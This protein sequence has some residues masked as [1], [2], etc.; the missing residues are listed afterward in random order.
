MYEKE[1]DSTINSG[2]YHDKLELNNAY[3]HEDGLKV[4]HTFNGL[5]SLVK[6]SVTYMSFTFASCQPTSKILSQ[7]A[8]FKA[9]INSSVVYQLYRLD[10]YGYGA[11]SWRNATLLAY[12]G[13]SKTF[14]KCYSVFYRFGIRWTTA[15]DECWIRQQRLVSIHYSLEQQLLKYMLRNFRYVDM[16]V[17]D[18]DTA[19]SKTSPPDPFFHAHI[20]EDRCLTCVAFIQ[21][22]LSDSFLPHLYNGTLNYTVDGIPCQRWEDTYPHHHGYIIREYVFQDDSLMLTKNYCRDPEVNGYIWCFTLDPKERWQKCSQPTK[23][24]DNIFPNRYIGRLSKT[25]S[26]RTCQRW[27]SQEPHPQ[28]AGKSNSSF[29]DATVHDAENYCRDPTEEGTLFCYTTDP[30]R[31]WEPCNYKDTAADRCYAT[32]S[33]YL[34]QWSQTQSGKECQHWATHN[35]LSNSQFPDGSV[36]EAKNYCRDP[37]K[38]G[39]LWCFTTDSVVAS[40]PCVFNYKFMDKDNATSREYDEEM[41]E[42]ANGDN[43]PLRYLCN[44][45]QNCMDFSDETNCFRTVHELLVNKTTPNDLAG[46][47][48]NSSLFQ[49]T[50][51]EWI[52]MIARCDGVID[53]LDATDEVNCS[54]TKGM[55]V[56]SPCSVEQFACGDKMCIHISQMCDFFVDCV[57]ASDENCDYPECSA[58][59]F[60][61]SNGQCIPNEKRCD[62]YEQCIDGTDENS[63]D[64]CKEEAFHCD[65]V[66]CIPRRLV[67]DKYPDCKDKIDE[68]S[69]DQPR[70]LSCEEWWEAGYRQNGI[71]RLNETNA[72]CDFESVPYDGKIFTKFHN[73]EVSLM[74]DYERIHATEGELYQTNL[75]DFSMINILTHPDYTCIQNITLTCIPVQ[76]AAVQVMGSDIESTSN[77]S[78]CTCIVLTV[79]PCRRSQA[80][81]YCNDT[82]VLS[83]DEQEQNMLFTFA[84]WN[85]ERRIIYITEEGLP[86][87]KELQLGPV[88]CEHNET[89][90]KTSVGC[91]NENNVFPYPVRCVYDTDAAGFVIGCRSGKHLQGCEEFQC[92]AHTVKCP[93]SFCIPLRFVCDGVKQCPDGNDEKD[94][95]CQDNDRE[96][97]I[98]YENTRNQ[99]RIQ[100]MRTLAR[101]FHTQNSIVRVLQYQARTNP[102]RLS[103]E[104]RILDISDELVKP[105]ETVMRQFVCNYSIL[106]S[107]FIN[108]IQF[109]K[110]GSA[111]IVFIQN[112]I[113]SEIIADMMFGSVR[114]KP[115]FDLYRVRRETGDIAREDQF[116]FVTDVL[117][118]RWE[119]MPTVGTMFF[120]R[121]CQDSSR[122]YCPGEYKCAASKKC[123]SLEQVCD[124]HKQCFH[125]DDERLCQYTC[126]SKCNCSE[127]T[128]NCSYAN[129]DK[130]TWSRI[131]INSR[132]LDLSGNPGLHDVLRDSILE[133][134]YL[135]SLYM[136]RCGIQLRSYGFQLLINLRILDLSYNN[137]S[138]LPVFGF[139]GLGKL[140]SLNLLG[141]TDI[142]RIEPYALQ[143][144]QSLRKLKIARAN[145]SF[146]SSNAFAG[147]RLDILNLTDNRIYEM[148][149]NV[150]GDLNVDRIDFMR[151][152]IEN[153]DKGLFT[154]VTGLTKLHTPSYKYCCIRPNYLQEE[155]CF[156][157]KDEFS[158]CEDLLRLSALQTMLW[159]IGLCG[160]FGN[161]LSVIYRLVY[162]RERLKLSYE[163]FVTNLAVADALMG[164]YLLIIA[165]ADAVYRNRYIFMDDSWRSSGWC[166]LAG[167]LSTVSSEA[168]VFFLCLITLDRFLVVKYPFGDIRLSSKHVKFVSLF[169]W[170]AS[171]LIAIVP[172]VFKSYFHRQFYSKSGVCIALPL[173]RDRPPGWL[174]SVVIFIGLNFVT[175]CLIALG[176]ASI[177]MEINKVRSGIRSA[178]SKNVKIGQRREMAVARNLLLVATTDFMCWF[179]IGCIGFLA[180]SGYEISGDVYAWTTVFILPVN[181]ALNPVLYTLSV[182]KTNRKQ[183]SQ[184]PR[185]VE[186]TLNRKS[187]KRPG[188]LA[189]LFR[190]FV[191]RDNTTQTFIRSNEIACTNQRLRTATVVKIST[192]LAHCLHLLQRNSLMV[193]QLDPCVLYVNT[194]NN[195]IVGDI[196]LR[197]EPKFC[198]N[199]RRYKDEIYRLGNI[200]Q[201]L[202]I[203]VHDSKPSNVNA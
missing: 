44:G 151:N 81:T 126:P 196:Q 92:P 184:Q 76:L 63:C 127:Y 178:V 20:G 165:A 102:D 77:N 55:E 49:C 56:D 123:I 64:F 168:S 73:F 65:L 202:V 183:K 11:L 48:K 7:G 175:F 154:G 107:D 95:G 10:L 128:A 19:F 99:D 143:G 45:K 133:F 62:G 12:K 164:I 186:S 14:G 41:F 68:M 177:Y 179:P 148:E 182:I 130:T 54:V 158:S 91:E 38:E 67:C 28:N 80:A 118:K 113:E 36:T 170:A 29:P 83:E 171:V 30:D 117:I 22:N 187:I 86:R 33:S 173:T 34:G 135:I 137:I 46:P 167:F 71:Y 5:L 2:C 119:I 90:T 39:F 61:C 6:S 88:V 115:D 141:N 199:F 185:T 195:E 32:I 42:C 200:L 18:I 53:C 157:N 147:L 190:Y 72:E 156:P 193:D 145:I 96:V 75:S 66:R 100:Q 132:L 198:R 97:L 87:N 201:Y 35:T 176:Q 146:I 129:I 192:Q 40:E 149:D 85:L 108:Y 70:Y 120:P 104:H 74:S 140:T 131:H 24:L 58:Q 57:D 109:S 93:R 116:N 181:S 174:Y 101:E 69:C 163:I 153:F 166:T 98:M 144:L 13:C 89:F 172:I 124:G 105:H 78:Y 160:L 103:F 51:K 142:Y 136:S 17:Y 191:L 139:A 21:S 114:V 197:I 111:G 203:L 25:N 188:R 152:I 26:G 189:D 47:W 79:A 1:T 59:E 194:K 180:M 16:G 94:C 161:T 150:F 52:S 8:G 138:T 159:L 84:E 110:N 162:H 121:L 43:V 23:V 50:N 106:A 9:I 15:G 82:R 60:R 27:D 122:V 125:G 4:D 112:S 134:P 31:E 155:N 3:T 37:Y 169:S